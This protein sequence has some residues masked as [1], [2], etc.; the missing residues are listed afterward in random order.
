MV[1]GYVFA[2]W[3]CDGQTALNVWHNRP[4]LKPFAAMVDPAYDQGKDSMA[5][6]T[7]KEKEYWS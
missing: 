1:A 6:K 5:Y 7:M 4:D 3:Y 2:K